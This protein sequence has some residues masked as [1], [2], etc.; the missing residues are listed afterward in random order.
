MICFKKS[1]RNCQ[2]SRQVQREAEAE[3]RAQ[4]NPARLVEENTHLIE[5][6]MERRN[7]MQMGEVTALP[8]ASTI[9][10]EE[11]PTRRSITE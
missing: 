4:E 5:V 11:L 8:G 2:R 10:E 6:A 3:A 7:K 9:M 1:K